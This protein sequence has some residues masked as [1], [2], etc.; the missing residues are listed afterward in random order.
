[1]FYLIKSKIEKLYKSCRKAYKPKPVCE[2][3]WCRNSN[4]KFHL[5]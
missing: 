1:M 2:C 4:T 5:L 3:I